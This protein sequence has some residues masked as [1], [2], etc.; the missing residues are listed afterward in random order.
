MTSE[1]KSTT[2][3]NAFRTLTWNLGAYAAEKEHD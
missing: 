2:V 1:T 3:K